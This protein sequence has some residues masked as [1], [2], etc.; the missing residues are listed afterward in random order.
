ME[1][2]ASFHHKDRPRNEQV[3]DAH[4]IATAAAALACA[5]FAKSRRRSL[6][7]DSR[8]GIPKTANNALRIRINDLFING[9]TQPVQTRYARETTVKDSPKDPSWFRRELFVAR[10]ERGSTIRNAFLQED[11][12]FGVLWD[13]ELFSSLLCDT[14]IIKGYLGT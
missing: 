3:L 6:I 5:G 14:M 1:S 4:G 13:E 7:V 10:R 9:G 11:Y 2:N 8:R 12:C